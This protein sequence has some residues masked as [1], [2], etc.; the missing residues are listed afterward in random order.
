MKRHIR[1]V[2][3]LTLRSTVTLI[4]YDCP[5]SAEAECCVLPV[6][7][8]PFLSR[9]KNV[10]GLTLH[11]VEYLRCC[12]RFDNDTYTLNDTSGRED[13]FLRQCQNV[14]SADVCKKWAVAGSVQRLIS[15]LRVL[16]LSGCLLTSLKFLKHVQMTIDVPLVLLPKDT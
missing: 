11:C 9:K 1:C 8:V 3:I 16:P 15:G 2:V 12:K 4:A 6:A 7:L 13:L 14:F 5:T 10:N